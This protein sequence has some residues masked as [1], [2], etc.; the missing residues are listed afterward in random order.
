MARVSN[1]PQNVNPV[2]NTAFDRS[3]RAVEALTPVEQIAVERL[4]NKQIDALVARKRLDPDT[5]ADAKR[6]R[7]GTLGRWAVMRELHAR[8][9]ENRSQGRR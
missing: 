1:E 5:A 4:L 6:Q 2:S 8:S 7:L 9:Q 3:R